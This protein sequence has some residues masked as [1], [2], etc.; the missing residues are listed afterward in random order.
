[1]HSLR[2]F[3]LTVSLVVCAIT[4]CATPGPPKPP[5][6][7]L[8]EQTR[9]LT[10]TRIG[11][12]VQLRFTVPSRST[13]RLPLRGT[14]LTARFCR[15]LDAQPC[16]LLPST[17]VPLDPDTSRHASF[18]WTDTLPAD[19]TQG[20][21][22]LLRYNVELLNASSRSAGLSEPAF[23]AAGQAPL[24][25]AGLHA[26]GSRLGIVLGWDQS[27]QQ[28]GDIAFERQD[29]TT[30]VQF[31]GSTAAASLLDTS[32]K[33]GTAYRYTATRSVTVRLG[34]RAIE[35]RSSPSA[36]VEFML[37]PIYPPLAPVGL[38]AAP[39]TSAQDAAFA[40]DLIWQPVDD[41]GLITP[42]SGYNVY[43]AEG[44][45]QATRLNAVPL[46][47]PAFHDTS[48][49]AGRQYRYSVTAVDEKGNES[50]AVE[51]VVGP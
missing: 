8:P 12:T 27:P 45:A 26:Q 41:T 30:T 47:L 39:F 36:S 49:I 17:V 15:S 6:L 29:R 31:T 25:V 34:D 4:G 13:D 11:N 10:A 24:A 32:V 44:T 38:T 33:L 19:L 3:G 7:N 9:D 20:K 16:Q 28:S 48:A 21:P 42:L 51:V 35:L 40:V 50:L 37:K 5:S 2:R 23:T 14:N 43:R 46:T 1:M 18:T 22:R